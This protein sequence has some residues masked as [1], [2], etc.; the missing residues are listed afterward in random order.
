[1]GEKI[2]A[3][4][5]TDLTSV[6][7]AGRSGSRA[8][9]DPERLA[10]APES[11]DLIVAPLSLQ[12]VNDLP[13]AFIQMRRALKPDGAALAAMIGGASLNEARTAL[14]EAE[15]ELTGGAAARV[16]PFAD[17]RDLGGLLQRAGLAL[18]VT[19]VDR[20]TIRYD[21]PLK[22]VAD[23]R[24]LGETFAGSG[25]VRPLRRDVLARACQLYQERFADAD[26]RVRASLEILWAIGWAPHESQQKPLKPGSAEVSLT[27]I[28]GR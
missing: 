1:M 21:H 8:V 6:M 3:L 7:L 14:M 27:Q 10:L 20:F 17:V 13:G 2:G 23:L 25:A 16:A 12:Q 4:I 26:G 15:L 22:G 19:D 9:M 24:A 11:V 5:E 28:I 18:P